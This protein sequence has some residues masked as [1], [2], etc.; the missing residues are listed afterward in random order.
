MRRKNKTKREYIVC[1]RLN[2]E[3]YER[4]DKFVE[5]YDSTNADMLREFIR[6]GYEHE[7][8][9]DIEKLKEGRTYIFKPRFTPILQL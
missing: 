9:L 6:I 5:K 2:D 4:F 8:S 3:E 7:D 1:T